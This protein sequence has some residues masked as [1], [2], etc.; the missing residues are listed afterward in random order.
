MSRHPEPLEQI[1]ELYDRR[2]D[3]LSEKTMNDEAAMRRIF[4]GL[5]TLGKILKPLLRLEGL[6]PLQQRMGLELI[7]SRSLTADVLWAMHP[8]H[9]AIK[10]YL[11][12]VIACEDNKDRPLVWLEWCVSSDIIYMFD[13]QPICTEGLAAIMLLLDAG[14]NLELIDVAE[15]AG[16]PVEYCSAS[17]SAVGAALARQ[18]PAPDAI[19]TSSHPCDSIVSSYQSIEYI[20]DAPTF[21]LDTPYWEDERALDYYEGEVRRAIAF[22]EEHLGRKLDYDRMREVLTETNRTNELIMETNE[23]YRAKPCPGS[24]L[25]TIFAWVARVVGLGTPEVTEIARRLHKVTKDRMEK[26]VGTVRHEKIRII[27]FD[28][29]IAFYPVVTWMEETFGAVIVTDVVSFMAAPMIDTSTPDT[30]TR[31]L[32]E[33]IMNL[34]MARQFHGPAD[35]FMRDLMRICEEYNGDCFIWAGHAGCKHSAASIRM[36]KE[37]C[38]K[39]ELPLLVLS[40]D[41][42]DRRVTHEDKIKAQIEEFFV[43]SG[44]A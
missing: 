23:M 19:L 43:S 34:G 22:L 15:E 30:M 2:V 11:G 27:W 12:N 33:S 4:V 32:A 10:N 16:V 31:G 44:L 25:S 38:R 41:I 17:K 8:F 39:I 26:G 13:A 40:C 20:A 1:R 24:V 9:V 36:L 35:Y 5:R 28:V 7:S 21:R 18:F 3:L 42:F 29:P 6:I 14:S 37:Y